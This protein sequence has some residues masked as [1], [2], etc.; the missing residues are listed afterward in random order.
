M[1]R[2]GP[3]E[4]GVELLAATAVGQIPDRGHPSHPVGH[5]YELAE[6]GKPS[7]QRHG[8]P[9]QL[10]GPAAAVP[11]LVGSAQGHQH[12]VRQLQL[13]PQLL[14]HLGVVGDHA[15]DLAVTRQGELQADPEA[16]QRRV[17]GAKTAHAG[18]GASN[19][20]GT[21]GRTCPT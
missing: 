14:G 19:A 15:V 10:A 7:R 4:L 16:V 11:L 5:L 17:P 18:R 8:L 9:A 13:A 1:C 20:A 2:H 6:L 3:G 21:R 12:L